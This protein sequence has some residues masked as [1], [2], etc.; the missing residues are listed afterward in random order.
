MA[1]VSGG[2]NVETVF[3]EILQRIQDAGDLYVGFFAQEKYPD[4]TPVAAV[5]YWNEFG[6][7]TSPAR[8]FFRRMIAAK[9]AGW[10][11]A[12]GNIAKAQNYDFARVLPL[13]GEGIKDQLTQ[14]IVEFSD[15]PNAPYTIKKKG[16]NKPLIETAQ[17]SRAT[18]Y[19]VR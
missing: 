9:Q 15:P 3:S 16:F 18:G 4:G 12:F 13:M 8:P 11:V 2:D 19:E 10:G 6:T 5:A 1:S 17:M 7:A 14:S